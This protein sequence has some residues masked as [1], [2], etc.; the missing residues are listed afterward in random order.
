MFRFF[1]WL[2]ALILINT[3]L[4]ES[5]AQA[6]FIVF[7]VTTISLSLLSIIYYFCLLLVIRPSVKRKN[8]TYFW[9]YRWYAIVFPLVMFFTWAMSLISIIFPILL[10]SKLL[11]IDNGMRIY[12]VIVQLFNLEALGVFGA[13]FFLNSSLSVKNIVR[14]IGNSFKMFFYTYPVCFV[15]ATIGFFL[16]DKILFNTSMN[17]GYIM[18][19][20][21]LLGATRVVI[22]TN[23][24]IENVHKHSSN[25]LESSRSD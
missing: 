4:Y 23:I 24:Y 13:L 11:F 2:I 12:Y 6:H 8:W 9:S 20:R 22:Y 1:W 7:Y 16:G 21:M 19:I 14:A 25:Y 15:I 10:I 17:D 3:Y 5:Y 18:I